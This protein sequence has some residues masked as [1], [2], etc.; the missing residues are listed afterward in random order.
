M[1]GQLPGDRAV[2]GRQAHH[3]VADERQPV[4]VG[5]DRHA[6]ALLDLDVAR[7]RPVERRVLAAPAGGVGLAQH[8]SRQLLGLL[9]VRLVERVDAEHRS[10]DGGGDLPADELPAEVDRIAHVDPDDRVAGGL[11]RGGQLV[12]AP[13]GAAVERDPDERAV[14]AVRLDG[15]ERLAVDRHDPDAAL[16]GALGDELLE[17]RAEALDLVVDEERQLVAAVLRQRPD[18]QPERHARVDGRVRLAARA[19]HR[20][21]PSPGARRGRGR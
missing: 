4:T 2:V 16:A 11:E 18:R 20:R 3:R 14:R 21:S 17:P 9:H 12:A 10:G 7:T 19:D 13:G 8:A 6:L 5:E 15:P 1:A